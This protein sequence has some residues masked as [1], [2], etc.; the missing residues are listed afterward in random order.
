MTDT[1]IAPSPRRGCSTGPPARVEDGQVPFWRI[2]L[3]GCSQCCF[4]TNEVTGVIFLV[5]VLTYSW[6]QSLLMLMGAVIGAA[7]GLLLRGE[8]AL[9]ELGLF[10]FN[11]CLM[12]LA[13]GNFFDRTR[14][15]DRAA[16]LCVVV[17]VVAWAC[18]SGFR[19]RCS[20][21]RSSSSSGSCGHSPTISV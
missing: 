8:R 14:T 18:R 3:R 15:V 1:A 16:V 17:S 7:V 4:Q 6:E 9:L 19:I 11:S 20:P 2:V 12:A 5:A 10:G 21:R 13:L